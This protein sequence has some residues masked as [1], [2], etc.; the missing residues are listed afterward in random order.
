MRRFVTLVCLLF[1]T[2][3]FGISISGCSKKAAVVFCNGGDS[4]IV[5]G[6]T[7]TITL[8]PRIYGVSLNYGQF[9]QISAPTATDCKGTAT[10]VSGYTY[11]TTDM[12]IAD[13]VP[14]TGRLCAGTWN[15]NTG[16]GIADYTTCMA[17]NKTGTAYVTASANGASSNPLPVFVHPVVTSV[18]LGSPTATANCS[19]DP[20][21]SSNCCPLAAQATVVAPAYNTNSCLSQGST[22]Q[23]VA[24]VYQNATNTPANNITCQVGHLAYTAQAGGVVTIDENGVATAQAP[25]STIITATVANAGSSAGFFST[26]PP[27]S[28]TLTI[29]NASGPN[30]SAVTVNQNF[31][32]AITPTIKD[33]HGVTLT[34]LTLQYVSTTPTIIPSGAVASVTPIF[35]GA[36]TI[37]AICEPPSCNPSPLNEVGLLGNG[38]PITSNPLQVTSPGV[39]STILYMASSKSL[40]LAAVDFTTNIVGNPVRLPYVPNSMVISNDG[41]SIYLGSSTE[42][43]VYNATTAGLTREDETLPGNVL[44]VSPDN[45]T[46]V[47]SD[48]VRQVIS[49]ANAAGGVQTTFGG[50]GTHAEFSADGQTLY[51]TAGSQLLVHSLFTGWTSI[52]LTTPATDVAV[53]V[54]SVGVF[55]AGAT[56]TARGYCPQ[57]TSTTTAGQTTTSN[58]YYPDAGIAGPT[59][60]RLGVTNDGV[61]VIGATVTPV[62]TINDLVIS[63]AGATGGQTGLPTGA[64]P[65][66]GLKFMASPALTNVLPG[67]VATS[68]DGVVVATDSSAAFVT[69]TGSGGVLPLYLPAAS[70]AGTLASVKLSGAAVAP[71]S[72]V[73]SADNATF[74]AGTSGDNLVHLVTKGAAGYTDTSTLAPKLPDVNGNIVAPD[75]LV[76]KPRK[77]I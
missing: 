36:G 2:I 41:T 54:P 14:A 11:G 22:G 29:P 3:P 64:C 43:M 69:Y 68:I 74:F 50:V 17:T 12:T 39:N 8:V 1:F 18:V 47:V 73:F 51:V 38:T 71:V 24:R 31:T 13:V 27:A 70:G 66:S 61:H 60:D 4:G 72:G 35:A 63:P 76:Q 48:P 25:G 59:T 45:T 65:A 23:L 6:Q 5:V 9:G 19:T 49:M 37:S 58:V 52:P 28:I 26:C 53:A 7:T 20:D 32:Q 75:L 46:I 44:A 42:L 30:P 33:I 40:Y 15:R 56:T 34:G 77:T 10:P 16:G 67:V 62:P 55:L 21:A 57:T